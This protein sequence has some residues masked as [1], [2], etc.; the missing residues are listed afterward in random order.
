M[1]YLN[2]RRLNFL[3]NE[4]YKK[5]LKEYY[6]NEILQLTNEYPD[7]KS[8]HIRYSKIDLFDK[9]I[10]K[11]TLNHPA[12]VI[13]EFESALKEIDLPI[14]KTFEEVY[15]RITDVPTKVRISDLRSK[16]LGKLVAIE[17]MIRKTTEVR[18][19]CTKAAFQCLRC[20]HITYVEQNSYKF[21][22]PF[23][24][25]EEETCGK[26][27]PFKVLIEDSTF[28]DAQKL[29]I[30]EPP[31]DLRGT[32]SQCLDIDAD[33]DLT[34][35][36]LP[37]ERVVIS[38]I[39]QSRQRTLKDG[40]SPYY[41]IFLEANS[42][43]RQGTAFDEIEITSSDE[44]EIIT[45]SQDPLVYKK[46][47]DSI[48]PLIKGMDEVKEAMVL[49]L[50]SGVPKLIPGAGYLRGDCH[51]LI[52]TDPS[53]GKSTLMKSAQARSPRAIFTGGKNTTAGG[54]TAV[55]VK[56]NTNFGEG[57]WT[58]EGGALVLADKGIA[59]IDEADKM[60]PSDRDALHEAMEQQEINISKA[61]IVATLK[62]RTSVF[63]AANPKYGQYDKY[64]GLADQINMPPSLLSR[65]DLIFIMLDTPNQKE[66][67]EISEHMLK[68]HRAGEIKQQR[69]NSSTAISSVLAE[70]ALSHVTPEISVDLFK[71]YI[72]YA[73]KHVFPVLSDEAMSHIHNFYLNL[74]SM[75]EKSKT[76]A[77][78]ITRRQEEAMV[79]LAEASARVRLSPTVS[80]DDANR[81][82][83]LMEYCLKNI[84]L[85]PN[86]GEIDA[87]LLNSGIS[88]D[89]RNTNKILRDILKDLSKQN[90]KGRVPILD[91]INEAVSSGIE[92]ARA[93]KAI[94]KM[95][96]KGELLKPDE[97]HVKTVSN[98]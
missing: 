9:N 81:A 53:L 41:D 37:G 17:G 49:Q 47:T 8:L 69:E 18:P 83:H 89:Q 13:P 4:T 82:T 50:F 80:L 73:R 48:A 42:I 20:G 32:Q 84:G 60:K 19:R 27:G 12:T 78:P 21:E 30:Q 34:G 92:Q 70:E 66:D 58:I 88:L 65:F 63:M 40:K 86:T 44:A 22:E 94:D 64:E 95:I 3:V 68:T 6:W 93:E 71:K 91:L 75:A 59:F 11:E 36:L 52:V 24:G 57:R 16:H 96:Q 2:Y 54:L 98:I 33:N 46:T 67:A 51:L 23:A 38:G 7:V 76:K 77:T 39:L 56:E 10:A 85:D 35:L 5:F 61:G 1:F 26:K 31:E 79:R 72:A 45:L 28:V 29:Q 74:R 43:E 87:G 62:T 14:D 97:S 15:I 90:V 55:A 25:C